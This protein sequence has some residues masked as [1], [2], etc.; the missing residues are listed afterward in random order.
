MEL[1][2]L[3]QLVAI[4][5]AKTISKAAE[6]LLISQPALTRSIQKLEEE[7]DLKLFDRKK[8]KVT[9]NDNGAL[10]VQ[11]AREVL[12]NASEMVMK[13]QAYDKSKHTI[14][15]GSC[16]PAP[17]WGLNYS[18]K[19]LFPEMKLENEIHAQDE[20]LTEGLKKDQ[21]TIVVV[22]RPINDKQLICEKMFTE[23]LYL[24]VPPAH[25]LAMAKAISFDDLNGESVLLLSRIGFWNELCLNKLPDSHLLIQDDASIFNELT[26]ASALP[27]FSTNITIQRLTHQENR[28]YV[29]ITDDEARLTYYMVYQKKDKARFSALKYAVDHIDWP[30]TLS[31]YYASR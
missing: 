23:E 24:S 8:N 12:G 9:L 2:Q 6:K 15:I 31:E 17:V 4:A 22:M 28:V 3:E 21:Y 11:Y 10:A 19:I 16:A 20:A 5:E 25:P 29:P 1:Y 26:K 14:R 7:L 13:L 30:E 27:C 18:F